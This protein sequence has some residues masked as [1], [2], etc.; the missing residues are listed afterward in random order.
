MEQQKTE[1]QPPWMAY[2]PGEN[3]PT[4]SLTIVSVTSRTGMTK[5]SWYRAIS[6]GRAPAARLRGGRA[7]WDSREIEAW[8]RWQMDTLPRRAS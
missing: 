3:W 7:V 2:H 5:S 4:E 1:P 8:N 6:A